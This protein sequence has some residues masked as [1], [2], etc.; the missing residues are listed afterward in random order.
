MSSNE[1]LPW[2]ARRA[3]KRRINTTVA[4][5]AIADINKSRTGGLRSIASQVVRAEMVVRLALTGA[6]SLMA[7]C[8]SD[9]RETYVFKV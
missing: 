1:K 4:I 8:I 9:S 6:K 2:P 7:I 5:Q 3:L